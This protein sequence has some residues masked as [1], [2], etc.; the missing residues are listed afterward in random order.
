MIIVEKNAG[1][2]I[3]YSVNRNQ[4]KI[5]FEGDANDLSLKLERL[6]QDW[7]IH[8]DI[9]ID[10]DGDLTLGV[11]T[12]RYYCAEVD[13]PAREYEET[14]EDGETVK[15]ALPLDLDKVT[16]SLWSIDDL[17]PAEPEE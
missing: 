2:K 15:E 16:L 6:Q 8:K 11:A 7:P 17:T 12:G 3:D 13:I 9:C 10:E 14:E 4:K 5:T 1:T